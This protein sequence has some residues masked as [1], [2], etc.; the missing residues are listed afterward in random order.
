MIMASSIP[1]P[2]ADDYI[3][4]EDCPEWLNT[5]SPFDNLDE[6]WKQLIVF[7]VFHVPVVGVSARA[8]PL[9][10]FGWGTK[11]KHDD[12]KQLKRKLIKYGNMTSDSFLCEDSWV[13]LKASIITNGLDPFPDNIVKERVTYRKA[14]TGEVDSLL[15]HIRNSFA[16][17][18]LAFFDEQNEVYIVMEDVDDKKHVSARLILSKTTMIRWKI[19]IESGPFLSNDELE[20]RLEWKV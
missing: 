3:V 8:K 10:F 13:K 17:G 11:S 14:K 1:K 20:K 15:A 19:I 6:E 2:S 9:E 7:Y 4:A 16:H 5:P 18:R 12:F